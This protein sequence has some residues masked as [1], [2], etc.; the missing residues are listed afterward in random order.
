MVNI[1]SKPLPLLNVIPWPA[2][3]NPVVV[4]ADV[5]TVPVK[6]GDALASF[7]FNAVCVAVD[8]GLFQSVVLLT[9]P[10]LI[11]VAVIPLTVPVNVG[12]AKGANKF[13]AVCVAVDI[14]FDKSVVLLH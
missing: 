2:V 11:I 9:S 14:G 5:V 3:I 10:K 13:N 12:D 6:V 1:L 4:N 7:K 8:I